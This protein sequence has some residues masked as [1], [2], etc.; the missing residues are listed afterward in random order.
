MSKKFQVLLLLILCHICNTWRRPWTAKCSCS[1]AWESVTS[2]AYNIYRSPC[3][4]SCTYLGKLKHTFFCR[5]YL[6]GCR[7][8]QN[9]LKLPFHVIVWKNPSSFFFLLS[10]QPWW[11]LS[12]PKNGGTVGFEPSPSLSCHCSL[13]HS[14]G[15]ISSRTEFV[16][17]FSL[18]QK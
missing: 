10:R 3:Y 5:L 13:L 12:S 18:F 11:I 16:L 2:N 8:T 14:V 15:T 7:Q 9:T 6:H 1:R 17:T 4:T